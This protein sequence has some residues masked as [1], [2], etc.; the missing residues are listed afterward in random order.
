MK[1]ILKVESLRENKVILQNEN[2]DNFVWPLSSLPFQI[3]IGDEL[4][5]TVNKDSDIKED[6]L[7]AKNIINDILNMEN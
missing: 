4:I 3:N 5:F 6:K 7:I 1:I 2:G